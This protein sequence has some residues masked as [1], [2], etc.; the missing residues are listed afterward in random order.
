MADSLTVAARALLAAKRKQYSTASGNVVAFDGD[1][2]LLRGLTVGIEPVQPGSGD[3]SPDNVRPI[4][5]W[6]G[7]NGG[8]DHEI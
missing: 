6:T 5:G 8:H 7:C 1:G 2:S 3:P 4:S